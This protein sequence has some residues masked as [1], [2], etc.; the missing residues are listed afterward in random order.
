[1]SFCKEDLYN[2]WQ[3]YTIDYFIDILNGTYDL[4]TA[5]EDLKSLIGSKYD[6]RTENKDEK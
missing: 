3:P 5:R 4:E 6:A 2:C 1:M